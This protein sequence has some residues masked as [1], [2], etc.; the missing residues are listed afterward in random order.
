MRLL[1]CH[2]STKVER[3]C[4]G[5]DCFAPMVC[6]ILYKKYKL[7][8]IFILGVFWYLFFTN[9]W[10]SRTT[11][12][13]C[14]IKPLKPLDRWQ[15]MVCVRSRGDNIHQ[16]S[17]H[18]PNSDIHKKSSPLHSPHTYQTCIKV[19]PS[20]FQWWCK[21]ELQGLC[22]WVRIAARTLAQAGPTELAAIQSPPNIIETN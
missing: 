18:D 10:N 20:T 6:L 3:C 11:S 15:P 19:V 13:G 4:Y 8:L 2:C 17:H 21:L 12:S 16:H 1:L 7:N 9:A 14:H 5:V 22:V